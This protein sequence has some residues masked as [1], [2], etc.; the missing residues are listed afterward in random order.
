MLSELVNDSRYALRKLTA[1]PVFAASAILIVALGIGANTA[2]FSLID[3]VLMRPLPVPDAQRISAVYTYDKKHAT[4]LST[5]YPDFQDLQRRSSSFE[6]MSVYVR[7]AMKLDAGEHTERLPAEAVS[8]NYFSTLQLNPVVGRAF[9]PSDD[10]AGA[11]PA[12]MLSEELWTS[13]FNRDPKLI[14]KRIAIEEHPAVV[15]GIV[16]K[17]YQGANLNWS[18]PPQ[19][20]LPIEALPGVMPRFRAL[21][22]LQRRNIR[23]LLI[24]GRVRPGTTIQSAGAE[25]ETLLSSLAAEHP[26]DRDLALR[27]FAAG[28]SKFWPAYRNSVATTLAVFAG[29]SVL[30]LLLACANISNLLLAKSIERRHEVAIRMALGVSRARLIRQLLTE[31]LVLAVPGF[32][33]ALILA[34]ALGSIL[35]QFPDGLGIPLSF[36]PQMDWQAIGFCGLLSL[37]TIALFSLAPAIR[38][39]RSELAAALQESG[40]RI[41]ARGHGG[42]PDALVLL[43]V[44]LSTVLLIGAALFTRSLLKG[45]SIDLGF[46]SAN[47][48]TAGF[49][50]PASQSDGEGK[51]QALNELLQ[52]IAE[53]PEVQGAVLVS[54]PP[55]SALRTT[56]RI[57]DPTRG[58]AEALSANYL[59]TTPGFFSLFRIPLIDGREF[60]SHDGAHSQ[61][62]GVVNETLARDLWPGMNPVGRTLLVQQ[63]QARIPIE[64]IGVARDARYGFVWD[65]PGDW[66]W[67][68]NGQWAIT[69]AD[70]V[71]RTRTGTNG[72]LPLFRASWKKFAPRAPLYDL[73]TVQQQVQLALAPQR[74][75]AGLLSAFG[76]LAALLAGVGI[77]GLLAS[78]VNRRRREL[79]I[80]LALGAR[81]T[82]IVRLVAARALLVVGIGAVIGTLF[83]IAG[84]PLVAAQ[85]KGIPRYDVPTFAAAWLLLL[86]VALAAI[87]PPVLRTTAMSPVEAL[88]QE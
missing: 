58:T 63:G 37:V 53:I 30:V 20:W 7:L 41:S 65:K 67:L 25:L 33:L 49:D 47:L 55:L 31:N 5:S 26:E 23:W 24:L 16:P 4:Y 82:V 68:A 35:A 81:Q 60:N 18:D 73:R 43:Q 75:A 40:S 42:L 77:Y 9:E 74:L 39:T 6:A 32:L 80:R 3:Q 70:L 29:A 19:I 87:L 50:L 8:S 34:K 52:S 27:T 66:L 11:I 61:K 36:S 78:S 10:S 84:M 13:E 45:Y 22:I 54:N 2:I 12:V 57:A 79:A 86:A 85:A 56:L 17:S 14:G 44:V 28:R 83:C 38:G 62:V 15:V 72:F 46:D 71:L 21:D 48:I 1:S 76:A 64:I 59:V 88:S 51:A 69:P